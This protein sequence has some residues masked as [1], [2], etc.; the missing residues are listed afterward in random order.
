LFKTTKK[1][2]EFERIQ[3]EKYQELGTKYLKSPRNTYNDISIIAHTLLYLDKFVLYRPF[4]QLYQ[5]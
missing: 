5:S 3:E 2:H 4:S 1:E